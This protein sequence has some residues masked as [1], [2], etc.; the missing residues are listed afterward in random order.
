[1]DDL[2]GLEARVVLARRYLAALSLP[3]G[4]QWKSRTENAVA[5]H[6]G[7]PETYALLHPQYFRDDAALRVRLQ[8]RR[9][10]GARDLDTLRGYG[11]LSVRVWGYQCDLAI[12]H[13]LHADHVFPYSL[14]GSTASSNLLPLCSYHNQVKA[15]DIHLYPHWLN[16]PEWVWTGLSRRLREMG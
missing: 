9:S 14:G 8:G 15:H 2:N 1:M 12:G 11:C 5:E 16:P 3:P 13:P 4:L 10:F 7:A 6:H